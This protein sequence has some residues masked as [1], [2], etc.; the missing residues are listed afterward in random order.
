MT[1]GH[2]HKIRKYARAKN[3]IIIDLIAYRKYFFPIR[4]SRKNNIFMKPYLV[5]MNHS[6]ARFSI[7]IEPHYLLECPDGLT[8]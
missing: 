7:L 4:R 6:D 3:L 5:N 2:S 8:L 1:S